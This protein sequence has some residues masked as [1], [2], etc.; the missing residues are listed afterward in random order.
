MA[1]R[2]EAFLDTTKIEATSGVTYG[3]TRP[4]K[5]ASN[6]LAFPSA[7]ST[8]QNYH[9]L[10]AVGASILTG[11]NTALALLSAN[12]GFAGIVPTYATSTD[13]LAFTQP[14][15]AA[16]TWNG[17]T[18]NNVMYPPGLGDVSGG[19]TGKRWSITAHFYHEDTAQWVVMMRGWDVNFGAFLY[20]SPN[21]YGP[22]TFASTVY[23]YNTGFPSVDPQC[24]VQRADGRW[25]SYYQKMSAGYPQ[26]GIPNGYYAGRRRDLGCLLSDST[27]LFGT[28]TDQGVVL[29]CAASSRQYYGASAWLS[30]ET[31]CVGVWIFDGTDNVPAA[32]TYNGTINRV[33]KIALYTGYTGLSLTLADDDWLP[34][35]GSIS[36]WDGGEVLTNSFPV[37]VGDETRLYFAADNAT[38]HQDWVAQGN[39]RHMGLGTW[40]RGRLGW[41]TGTGTARTSLITAVTAGQLTINSTGTV[42]AELLDASNNVITGY[43]QTDCDTIPSATFGHT[44]TW[45]GSA[46]TPA[47]FKV[48]L[49]LTSATV[50]YLTAEE[51]EGTAAE[52]YGTNVS[53]GYGTAT[54]YVTAG[55][56]TIDPASTAWEQ[57]DTAIIVRTTARGEY[58]APSTVEATVVSAAGGLVRF[59]GTDASRF[60]VSLD[61]VTWGSTLDVA[62]GETPIYLRVTPTVPGA[63]LSAEIGV[64]T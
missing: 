4:T 30:G 31:V 61:G 11:G 22:W 17:S 27:D 45:G 10:S 57:V 62:A 55:T 21:P 47:A 49:Y 15:L 19:G 28:W 2:E 34:A 38:H 48:K 51:W 36:D 60:A 32:N 6:P 37:T 5:H 39:R 63:T 14:N 13:G 23:A 25:L 1:L 12:T 56:L 3:V 59:R 52:G 24:L 53:A 43:A 16:V 29:S 26:T 9:T 7:A 46:I 18:T 41:I 8:N 33:H 20:T 50:Y 44:V 42:K 40:G 64:P 35:T 54:L 58:P